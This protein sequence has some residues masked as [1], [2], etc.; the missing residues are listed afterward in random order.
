M[1]FKVQIPLVL[2]TGLLSNET[3]WQYQVKALSGI[4]KVQIITSQENTPEK[5][6]LNILD[7]A[8]PKFLL[9]GHS[10]G[11]WLCLEIMKRAP[12]RVIKLC[13][14]NT[15]ARSDSKEKKEKRSNMI[16]RAKNGQF[17]QLIKENIENFIWNLGMKN[18]V[19]K[20]FLS[21]GPEALIAQEEAM[22]AREECLSVLPM[23]G[24]P[25]LVIHAAHDKIFSL[26]EHIEL[27]NRVQN[28]TLTVIENSGHMSPMENPEAVTDAIRKWLV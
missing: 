17:E 2:L 10:M 14:L 3:V 19:E 11:G 8:P 9:A 1:S 26:E 23:I 6:I 7:K 5:M 13:L 25:T 15:T 27:S 4:V 24:C 16:Q 22:L 21:V 12:E 18:D 20:M 28:G